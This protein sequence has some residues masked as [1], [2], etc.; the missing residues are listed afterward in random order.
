MKVRFFSHQ[1]IIYVPL[2]CVKLPVEAYFD[3]DFAEIE[4]KVVSFWV[5]VGLNTWRMVFMD[6]YIRV[7]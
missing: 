1:T 4:T 6:M 2:N 5:T 7:E 3:R